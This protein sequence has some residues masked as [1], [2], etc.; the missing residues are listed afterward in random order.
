MFRPNDLP[1]DRTSRPLR[2]HPSRQS[3]ESRE[4]AGRNRLDGRGV[5]GRPVRVRKS[6]AVPSAPLGMTRRLATGASAARDAR[7]A[8]FGRHDVALEQQGVRGVGAEKPA[9][10]LFAMQAE[11]LADTV[12]RSR[13]R[14]AAPAPAPAG[15]RVDVGIAG[16]EQRDVDQGLA[17][18]SL[19]IGSSGH[20]EIVNWSLRRG[21]IGAVRDVVSCGATAQPGQM[22]R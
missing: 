18:C 12:A 3:A 13:R 10:G 14:A 21:V 19:V 2:A 8:V 22:T 7:S 17:S 16:R 15:A 11:R 20:C 4:P 5:V 9:D 6:R 1:Q